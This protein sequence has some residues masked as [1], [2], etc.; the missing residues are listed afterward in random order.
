M[1]KVPPNQGLGWTI[2]KSSHSRS[3]KRIFE[4]EILTKPSYQNFNSIRLAA[5][6]A[7]AIKLLFPQLIWFSFPAGLLRILF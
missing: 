5:W 1:H 7:K 4:K 6:K 2:L 3:R